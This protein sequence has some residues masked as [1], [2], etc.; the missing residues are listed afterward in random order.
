MDVLEHLEDDT[1]ALFEIRRVLKPNGYLFITIPMH[2][3]LWSKHDLKAMHYRRYEKQQLIN[4]LEQCNYSVISFSFWNVI[5]YPIVR[6]RR[7][8]AECEEIVYPGNFLNSLLKV[9]IA[10]ERYLPL[11]RVI[12]VSGIVVARAV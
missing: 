10:L 12:G 9:G 7:N 5:F 1:K 4:M 3:K 11:K 6:M 8:R 2:M